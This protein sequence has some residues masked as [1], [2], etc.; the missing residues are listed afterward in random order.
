MAKID[1]KLTTKYNEAVVMLSTTANAEIKIDNEIN[2][3]SNDDD[4]KQ[5]NHHP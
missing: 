3:G 4:E 2:D 1:K 5:E